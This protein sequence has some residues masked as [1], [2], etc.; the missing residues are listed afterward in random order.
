M[1]KCKT[2]HALCVWTWFQQININHINLTY[3]VPKIYESHYC[4][5]TIGRSYSQGSKP[6][7]LQK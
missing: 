7:H 3:V 2:F 4:F 5:Y 1:N 6:N